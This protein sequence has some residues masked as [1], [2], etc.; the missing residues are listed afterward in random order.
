MI[1]R[2]QKPRPRVGIVGDSWTPEESAQFAAWF[3]TVYTAKSLAMLT[4]QVTPSEVDVLLADE[5]GQKWDG[6]DGSHLLV[7]SGESEGW[8]PGPAKGLFVGRSSSWVASSTEYSEPPL[9]DLEIEA[10]RETN[11]TGARGRPVLSMGQ[12]GMYGIVTPEDDVAAISQAALI[13]AKVPRLPLA[14]AYTKDSGLNVAIIPGPTPDRLA[15]IRAFLNVWARSD[16]ERIP[17]FADWQSKPEW[18]V[19]EERKIHE[20]ILATERERDEAASRFGQRLAQLRSELTAAQDSANRAERRLITAKGDDLKAAVKDAFEK[21]GFVVDDMDAINSAAGKP[22]LEDLRIRILT[23]EWE[24]LAE[25]KGY[26]K[27]PGKSADFLDLQEYART[28]EKEKRRS[29]D[30][31]LYVVNGEFKSCPDPGTRRSPFPVRSDHLLKFAGAGGLV[32]PTKALFQTVACSHRS[33][34]SEARKAIQEQTGIYAFDEKNGPSVMGAE[35]GDGDE[36]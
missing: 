10:A 3:P 31:L 26:D 18:M 4:S 28:Y 8:M 21:L 20:Q 23:P 7:F 30:R 33:W 9:S 25:T 35:S 5:L 15:W 12:P 2:G 1:V 13:L 34:T 6:W 14:V 27:S 29:P 36:D 22:L 32:V 11:R 17:G 16:R 19:A 24:A